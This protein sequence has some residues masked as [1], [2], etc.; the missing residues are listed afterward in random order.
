MNAD[1][2]ADCL[3]KV[4]TRGL[5]LVAGTSRTDYEVLVR[6]GLARLVSGERP[7]DLVCRPTDLGR[8]FSDCVRRNKGKL[9]SE[10]STPTAQILD[11]YL[12]QARAEFICRLRWCALLWI[13]DE[14]CA[15]ADKLHKVEE[16]D[17]VDGRQVGL[18]PG[19]FPAAC[20]EDVPYGQD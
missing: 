9:W 14:Y 11:N 7:G 1:R 16:P 19:K 17:D 12:D 2:W 18:V 10:S 6:L 13:E 4:G 20:F 5:L 15:M 8:F 3:A